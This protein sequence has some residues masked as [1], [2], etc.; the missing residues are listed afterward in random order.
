MNDPVR[1]VL[2]PRFPRGVDEA[3]AGI[4]GIDLRTPD[5]ETFPDPATEILVTTDWDH[6]MLTGRL[7]WI[8]SIS[9]GV[10]QFP[11]DR[12]ESAGVVL[13]SASGVHAIPV[14]EHAIGLILAMTRGIAVAMRDAEHRVWRPR[15][16]QE[17]YG[18]TIGILGLGT[19]GSEVAVRAAALGMRVIGTRSRPEEGHPIADVVF[20]PDGTA[21]VFAE[22]DVVVSVLPGGESTDRIVGSAELDALGAG[23]FVNVGRGS[24][25]DEEALVRALE[26]G[27]IR[28]VALDVFETEPL[29]DDSAL[30]S[31]PRVVITPHTGGLSPAY[32]ARLADIFR[33]NLAA[34]HGTA[35]WV[36]RSI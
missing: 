5:E 26:T 19:I 34:F 33:R 9:A 7:R 3:L 6:V 25:V 31:H 21:A 17:L 30:W 24:T 12:L 10:D 1:V 35:D 2:H 27:I 23:W 18:K 11:L 14:A 28:G 13:T 15:M 36:N 32:G 8:Q 16:G 29:A 22:S 4:E 20:G